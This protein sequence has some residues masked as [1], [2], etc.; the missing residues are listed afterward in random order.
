MPK[1]KDR[2]ILDTNIWISFLISDSFSGFDALI[3][4]NNIE[5]L[6]CEELLQEFIDVVNRPKLK[7]IISDK[8]L[9]SLLKDIAQKAVFI[10]L[11]TI[12]NVCRD[13]KDNYLLSLCKDG[14]ATHLI[15]GDK[16]LLSLEKFEST[17]IQ[18]Y[19]SYI[20]DE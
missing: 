4:S 5:F 18:N 17:K 16:D 13:P 9:K 6:F 14:K 8:N 1:R 12:V 19:S 3:S 11:Q 2:I 15:S 10:E 20:C 7:K